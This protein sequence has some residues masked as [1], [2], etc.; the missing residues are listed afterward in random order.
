MQNLPQTK[1]QWV[2]ASLYVLSEYGLGKQ[3]IIEAKSF[4][5][6]IVE[7][8]VLFAFNKIKNLFLSKGKKDEP[9][10]TKPSD[11]APS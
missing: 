1:F 7:K 4:L 11:Q 6:L 9:I 10:S 3:T 2:I 8:P 5:E